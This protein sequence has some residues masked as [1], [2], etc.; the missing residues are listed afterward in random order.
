MTESTST[1]DVR[2]LSQIEPLELRAQVLKAYARA[3]NFPWIVSAPLLFVAF[4]MCL[5]MKHYTL[6]RAAVVLDT[7]KGKE[8]ADVTLVNESESAEDIERKTSP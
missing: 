7:K 1:G 5:F 4:L 2:G 8:N 3:I 6:Q